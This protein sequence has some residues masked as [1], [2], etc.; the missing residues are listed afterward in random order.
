MAG[1][2]AFQ[3][4]SVTY[5]I[6]AASVPPTPTLISSATPSLQPMNYVIQNAGTAW[7]S[8]GLGASQSIATSNATTPTPGTP[9]QSYMIAPGATVVVRA[10]ANLYATAIAATAGS[11]YITAG[12]GSP[13]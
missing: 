3:S 2:Q 6:A 13:I 10:T 4:Q 5:A 11:V 8:V 9:N 7:A 1:I 12:E